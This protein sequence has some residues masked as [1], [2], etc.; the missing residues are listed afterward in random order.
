MVE[1]G[2]CRKEGA[3]K[4]KPAGNRKCSSVGRASVLYSDGPG[5]DP[6]HL[7]NWCIH[8]VAAFSRL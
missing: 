8:D 7:L 1:R 4:P 6:S 3:Q 5:F 2:T